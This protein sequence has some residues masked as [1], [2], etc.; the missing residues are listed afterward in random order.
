MELGGVDR[1]T[2]ATLRRVLRT[3]DASWLPKAVLPGVE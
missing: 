1:Y 3:L 2:V